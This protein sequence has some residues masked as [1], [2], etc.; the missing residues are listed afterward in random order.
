MIEA[1]FVD[2]YCFIFVAFTLVLIYAINHKFGPLYFFLKYSIYKL[3]NGTVRFNF[4]RGFRK[5][6]IMTSY[7]VS[8]PSYN[9]VNFASK[10]KF[11]TNL[12]D[13]KAWFDFAKILHVGLK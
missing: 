10:L 7:D 1:D 4:L 11:L 5:Y 6:T 2:R 13:L 9:N 12:C 8:L 3:D